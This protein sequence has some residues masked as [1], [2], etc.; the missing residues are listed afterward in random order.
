M[1][2]IY[3]LLTW[4]TFWLMLLC[5]VF[6]LTVSVPRRDDL[7]SYKRVRLLL[8]WGVFF[9][10]TLVNLTELS[11]SDSGTNDDIWYTRL[12]TLWIGA[13]VAPV[14]SI[15]NIT[16]INS[17]FFS[18]RS[19]VRDLVIPLVLVAGNVFLFEIFSA[20]PLAFLFA[21][22]VFIIYYVFVVVAYTVIFLRNYRQYSIRL[23]NYFSEPGSNLLKWTVTTQFLATSSGIMAFVSLFMPHG[24]LCVFALFLNILYPYYAIRFINYAFQFPVI[25]PVVEE[26]MEEEP[27]VRDSVLMLEDIVGEWEKDKRYLQPELNIEMVA[28]ELSTNRTYL[29]S[30]INTCK[31]KNFKEWISDL[32]IAEAQC[33]LLA[34]P[35]TPINEI[36]ERVGFSDKGN[37]STRFSKS[38]GMS[39]SSWRKTH[40]K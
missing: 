29:S 9:L 30:Y 33:L 39:P 20:K 13:C 32:R 25:A 26:V 4:G 12:M 15:V 18:W 1:A 14:F 16:L 8:A 19:L 10:M 21:Y 37:F 3:Y 40:L 22:V 7:R 36:G 34:E 11:M 28:H 35:K 17:H 5:F 24:W 23:N 38:V 2:E 6:L 31:N 27:V